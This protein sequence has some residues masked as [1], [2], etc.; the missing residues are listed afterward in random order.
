MSSPD[1]SAARR[2]LLRRALERGAVSTQEQ[3]RAALAGQGHNV[4]QTTISRDLGAIGARKEGDGTYSLPAA[5]PEA[6]ALTTV[7]ERMR[8]FVTSLDASGN[9]AVLKTPPGAAH[10]VA[11]ALDE[12]PPGAIPELLGTIAGDDTM[13]LASRP[14]HDGDALITRLT[15]IMENGQ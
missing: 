15:Q 2:A 8:L 6:Q 9:L 11:V 7:A 10:S 4:S 12:A 3:L 1:R 14:P 13:F 5:A